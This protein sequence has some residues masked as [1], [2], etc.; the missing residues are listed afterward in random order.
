[1]TF[2]L[3][4]GHNN[5]S[6]VYFTL[7][8]VERGWAER[9][10]TRELAER[11]G[12]HGFVR[13]IDGGPGII[14]PYTSGSWDEA[15]QR[16]DASVS[17]VEA[18]SPHYQAPHAYVHR[19]L[20]RLGRGDATAAEHDTERSIE[21]A[22]TVKDPQLSQTTLILAAV[23]FIAI[24]N[25]QRAAETFGELLSTQAELHQLGFAGVDSYA[26]AWLAVT[27]RREE[28]VG[29]LLDSD[30]LDTPWIR[31]GKAV[32]AGDLAGAADLL[33]EIGARSQEAF[34]RLRAAEQ[35]VEAGRRVEADEQLNR[36]L[37]FYRSVGATRHVREGEAL[38]AASA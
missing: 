5:L 6:T 13:F 24:G 3:L 11:Y 20:I 32:L 1:L 21:L 10:K 33:G 23:V 8:E 34:L 27:L 15:L 35:L 7:G 31:A 25:E 29:E 2:D 9:V 38:L 4:R 28:E 26:M 19:A 17:E 36:A 14:H 18:G 37:A 16:A 30:P 22:R 12:H